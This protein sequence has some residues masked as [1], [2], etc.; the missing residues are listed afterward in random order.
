[1]RGSL[2]HYGYLHLGGCHR[3]LLS[4]TGQ[5]LLSAPSSATTSCAELEGTMAR[6][7]EAACFCRRGQ[8]SADVLAPAPVLQYR[9]MEG[10]VI[11]SA[12]VGMPGGLA[13]N[14]FAPNGL[15]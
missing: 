12:S 7:L 5:R 11:S 8:S 4:R 3:H 6:P 9:P 1:V 10:T 15:P 2:S 14:L 13:L